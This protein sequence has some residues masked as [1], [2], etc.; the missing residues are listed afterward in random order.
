MV[1]LE[2]STKCLQDQNHFF[3]TSTRKQEGRF[4]VSLFGGSAYM[5]IGSN[6]ENETTQASPTHE[7]RWGKTPTQ[8]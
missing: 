6:R 5:A 2:N 4:P 7:L 8:Y 3:A 1:S